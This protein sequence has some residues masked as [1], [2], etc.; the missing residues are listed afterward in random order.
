MKWSMEPPTISLLTTR[1][2]KINSTI[3]ERIP[4]VTTQVCL[5]NR[6]ISENVW[7]NDARSRL[8]WKVDKNAW[9]HQ[10]LQTLIANQCQIDIDI[11]HNRRYKPSKNS[12]TLLGIKAL[13][14]FSCKDS[15]IQRFYMC[16]IKVNMYIF[17]II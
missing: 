11:G 1:V 13:R 5:V 15:L 7:D 2:S 9:C 6:W 8:P 3:F 4:S 17:F 10:K 12:Y 14:I 16:I